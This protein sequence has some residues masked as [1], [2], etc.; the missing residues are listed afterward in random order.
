M[1]IWV[2]I[3][4]NEEKKAEKLI[5]EFFKNFNSKSSI[6]IKGQEA[7]IEVVFEKDPPRQLIDV[8]TDYDLIEFNFGKVLEEYTEDSDT[9]VET[10]DETKDSNTEVETLDETK[11]SNPEVETLDET[12]DSNT[13]VETPVNLTVHTTDNSKQIKNTEG[14]G[15]KS[16]ARKSRKIANVDILNIP[17]LGEIAKKAE[18]FEHFAKLI[19]E[20]LEM[21]KREEIFKNFVIVA[22]EIEEISLRTLEEALKNKN[23]SYTEWDKIS[24]SKQVGEKLK[25]YSVTFL[26]LLNALRQYKN[27][28]FG[29]DA[30]ESVDESVT[31]TITEP[32]NESVDETITG[33]EDTTS[34]NTVKM[35]C[36][37]EIP[38]FEEVLGSVDKTQP[39]EERVKHVLSAMGLDQNSQWKQQKI[40]KIINAAVRIKEISLDE[41][42]LKAE[43]PKDDTMVARMELSKFVNDFVKKYDSNKKVRL[44]D[45]F[46]QLQKIVINEGEI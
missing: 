39:I 26:P 21:D 31:E 30:I 25:D 12:K 35:E 9:E 34:K 44:L 32:D 2:K 43:I 38:M 24:I 40:F 33:F 23:V 19:A 13:E 14:N 5:R 10:P 37:P 27:Y 20:H 11:D 42:F 22:S 17:Q 3:R 7:K 18:S 6:V 29:G 46:E 41:I 4:L 16:T 8:I 15:G 45:F 36:M 28:P 1:K